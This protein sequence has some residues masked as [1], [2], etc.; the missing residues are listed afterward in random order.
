MSAASL[1]VVGGGPRALGVLMRLAA[2]AAE[3][4][5]GLGLRVHVVDPHPPGGGRIWRHAQSR[6]LWMNSLAED[7]TI[8]TDASVT[9]DGPVDD[10]PSLAEW[11]VGEGRETLHQNGWFDRE[12]PMRSTEF[13]PRAVQAD[14]LGWAWRRTL[15]R[16]PE[17]VEVVHH[18]T[19]A[20]ALD[21]LDDG[22][23]RVTLADGSPLDADA[24]V[25]AQGYLAQ[26]PSPTE[27]VWQAAAD[28]RGLTYVPTGHTADLDL[29]ELRPGEPVLVRGMGLAFVDLFVL[30]GEGRGGRFTG[31][32]DDLTY[33]PSG[34][35]PVLHVGST[36]GVP[37][38]AKLG[39]DVGAQ[40]PVALH[41]LRV[42]ALPDVGTLDW[43]EHLRPLVEREITDLHYR[44][45]FAAHPERT[46]GTWRDLERAIAT[47]PPGSPTL[48]AAVERQVPDPADRLDLRLLDR[49]LAGRAW[50]SGEA[51]EADVVA[52]VR[53]DIARRADASRSSDRAVFDGLLS[54]YAV[55]ATLAR[56]GRISSADR[57]IRFEREF[58][59]FFSYL[60]SG[61]RRG[62]S[63]SCSRCT[64]PASCASS[65]PT[66]RSSS[67]SAASSHARPR[68][69]PRCG[70]ARSWRRG[71]RDPTSRGSPTPSYVGWSPR[72]S[73][74]PKA[75]TTPPPA[76]SSPAS[77]RPTR[78]A[79]RCA[80]TA[81]RTP[82]GSSSV[83][84]SRAASAAAASSAPA[85][86]AP[87]CGRTTGS[88][89][90]CSAGS[91][92]PAKTPPPSRRSTVMPVEFLGMAANHD[93]TET[94]A[95]SGGALDLRYAAKLARAH[96]DNGWDRVLFAYHSGS[97]DPAQVA[98]FLAGQT[99]SLR[100]VVAHR[101]NTA[102]PTLTA[103]TLATLDHISDG[104]VEVHVITGGSTA[105]QAAE[106]DHLAKD[107]RY[108][109][110]REFIQILKQAW[111]SDEPFDFAGE[112]YQL[113]NFLADV[114]PVQQPRPRISFGG[115]SPAAYDVGAS[116]A[117]VFALWGEPLAGTREQIETI[118]R[119]AEAAG[120]PLPT[121]QVAFRP[122]LGATEELAWAKAESTLSEIEALTAV[123][124]SPRGR[125][126]RNGSTPEN[127]GS[128]RLLAAAE[129]GSGTTARC[130]PRRRGRPAAAATRQRWSAPPR[131]WRRRCWTTTTSAC[132]SSPPAAT[133]CTRPPSTS[134]ARSSRWC[135]RPSP[136]ASA[137]PASGSPREADQL[138]AGRQQSRPG[139]GG[140][141]QPP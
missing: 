103:K 90:T 67:P 121:I 2:N 134:A 39:Y 42:D 21:D 74:A 139:H 35:E 141:A 128:Q 102:A 57:V 113:E 12:Q 56:Q 124:N 83:P 78:S 97:P 25:L 44:R 34:R 87:R 17:G 72:A 30:L 135:A 68:C 138:H 80:P 107:D 3:V 99:D 75:C 65:A 55:L 11:A 130:G 46:R 1:V 8:F 28:G 20:V 45:L 61:P 109:R 53:A 106:G 23:Q 15:D 69:R 14:Y 86:T 79:G 110:T 82:T 137:R 7:V 63:R 117:D 108:G 6:L 22:R 50:D 111:T 33:H 38:R 60:A 123:G 10:G 48:L 101:P 126:R 54:I 27:R 58:H 77:S 73:C 85:S 84:R 47:E 116:E 26:R 136:S 125:L 105:D 91:R 133:T 94:R 59:G 51:L 66:S 100:L 122:I 43:D 104:R 129:S 95:R 81:A 52:H 49:P 89:D 92:A 76:G 29:S 9:C 36:R 62:A 127:A 4:A 119:A 5:P 93:G 40:G 31:T 120:R 114:K 37:Y 118:R 32:G 112:H 19:S 131:R 71:S 115:S 18:A 16:L 88:R 70:P 64:G 13:A 41:H 140:A 24:V 132:A 96:E 98:A